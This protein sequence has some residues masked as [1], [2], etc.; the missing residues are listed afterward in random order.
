L[1]QV[2]P[3]PV[4]EINRAV[5][6]AMRDGFE[7]GLALIDEILSRGDL[8]NYHWAYSARGELCRRLGKTAEARIAYQQALALAELEPQR[9]LLEK[10]MLTLSD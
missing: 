6:V 2:T 3:S 5:A 4:V 1:L 9:R 7:S 10:R 8:A